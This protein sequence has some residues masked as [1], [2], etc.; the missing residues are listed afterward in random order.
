MVRLKGGEGGPF[1]IREEIPAEKGDIWQ[2]GLAL[3]GESSREILVRNIEPRITVDRPVKSLPS[4]HCPVISGSGESGGMVGVKVAKHHQVSMVLQKG[5]KIR[6]LVPRT[7][8]RRGMYTLTKVNVFPR[9]LSRLPEL[10]LCHHRDEAPY[11]GW[12]GGRGG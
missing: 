7:K 4:G 3:G 2:V 10:P 9:G 8:G 5:V 12:S 1:H 11:W 6:G